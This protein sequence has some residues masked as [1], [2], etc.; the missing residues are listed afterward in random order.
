MNKKMISPMVAGVITIG[1]IGVGFGG[2][3]WY[4]KTQVA[5]NMRGGRF[6]Q[7]TGVNNRPG[8]PVGGAQSGIPNGNAMMGRGAVTGEITA[9]DDK[10]ITV[11]MADGS[12]K[13][14]I[15]SSDTKYTET[16]DATLDKVAV[17][18]KIAVFGS[19]GSDGTTTAATIEINPVTC[20]VQAPAQ[21]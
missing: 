4:Q 13:I 18:T 20:A 2:G 16:S 6:T 12:S 7:M 14:V 9:K 5:S 15:L 21:K 8:A 10:S 11:K 1:S 3:V 19:T 17:G